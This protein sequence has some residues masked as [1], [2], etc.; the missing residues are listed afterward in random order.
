VR[1]RGK[2]A[3]KAR[4]I[5]PKCLHGFLKFTPDMVCFDSRRERLPSTS[6]LELD[7]LSFS[8]CSPK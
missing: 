2:V 6:M 7:I 1:N 5:V 3:L 8:K 4:P